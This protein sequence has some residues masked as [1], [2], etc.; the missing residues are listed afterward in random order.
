VLSLD[1]WWK[2][3]GFFAEAFGLFGKA[4]FKGHGLLEPAAFHGGPPIFTVA[5]ILKTTVEFRLFTS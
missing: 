1:T 5:V 4:L 2:Q 3:T